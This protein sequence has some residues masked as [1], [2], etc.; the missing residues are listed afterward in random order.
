MRTRQILRTLLIDADDTLWENNIYYLQCTGRFQRL[1]GDVGFD[2]EIVRDRLD[3]CERENIPRLGYG[4]ESY[5]TSLVMTCELLLHTEGRRATRSLLDSVRSCASLVLSPPMVLIRGV[6]ETLSELRWT[7]RLGLVTKG[8]DDAQRAKLARSGLETSFDAV[9]ILAE[10]DACAYESILS[11][12]DIR[13]E[14]TWMVGNS[15]RSDINPPTEV[16]LGAVLI[17]HEH[18]WT[19]EHQEILR[20]ERVSTIARFTALTALFA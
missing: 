3:A 1:M 19:V 6:E 9:Y 14:N 8:S 17:P 20:P 2:P 11:D 12:L 16:G 7:S 13:P 18:T 5:A 15:P 4:P 10:K